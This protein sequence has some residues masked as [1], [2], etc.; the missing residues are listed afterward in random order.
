MGEPRCRFMIAKAAMHAR[1]DRRE[2]DNVKRFRP[3]VRCGFLAAAVSAVLPAGCGGGSPAPME[4]GGIVAQAERESDHGSPRLD[5][6]I[7]TLSNRADLISD[8]DA[9]VEV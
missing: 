7:R 8:G 6:E 3:I 4:P 1:A 2:G 9:L 5:F